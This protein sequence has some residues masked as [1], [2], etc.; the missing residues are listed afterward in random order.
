[1]PAEARRTG[2]FASER[3]RPEAAR[4][5]PR[6]PAGWWRT[7][8]DDAYYQLHDPLFQEE[9]SRTEVAAMRELL[10]LPWRARVLDMP[11]GWGRHTH[12]LAKAGCHA[13]GADLSFPLLRRA[14][15]RRGRRSAADLRYCRS[16]RPRSMPW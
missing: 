8:F 4:P 13:F 14:A 7:Y 3:S 9:A 1:M 12:L 15:G 10:G 2:D 11:C 5:S 6:A 16:R